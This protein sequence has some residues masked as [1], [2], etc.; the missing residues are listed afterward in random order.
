MK[1]FL[2][3]ILIAATLLCL[4][5]CGSG[6]KP[7]HNPERDEDGSYIFKDD[8]A[9]SIGTV[10]NPV[11]AQ[12]IYNSI[13]YIPEMFYGK[14]S[15]GDDETA[16]QSYRNDVGFMDVNEQTFKLPYDSLEKI[17]TIPYAIWAG[18]ENFSHV[19]NYI[20]NR[21]WANLYF[22]NE[23]GNLVSVY[24]A[25]EISDNQIIFTPLLNWKYDEENQK[26]SYQLS[27]VQFTYDF[28]FSGPHLTLSSGGKS[29]M[30]TA[31]R[32]TT[33]Q[34]FLMGEGY[35]KPG[36]EG[37]GDVSY[38][39]TYN[40][41]LSLSD[42][43]DDS[44]SA[45]IAKFSKDGLVTIT[46]SDELGNSYTRQMVYFLCSFDGYV[47]A[48]QQGVYC[49]TATWSEYRG[50]N[51]TGNI[52]FEEM[53]KLEN[54]PQDELTQIIEKKENL[55]TDLAAAYADSGLAV[56]INETTGEITLDS[57]V[58]FDVNAYEVSAEGKEFLKKFI[59]I[60]TSVVFAEKYDGFV[61]KII[62]EGH[63]D[64]NGDYDMNM[65]LSQ[66]RA[67]SVMNYCLSEECGIDADTLSA[68]QSTM[69]SVGYSFENPIYDENGD[70]DMAASRRVSFRFIVSLSN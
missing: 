28:S 8:D 20:T 40:G 15:L 66:N 55:L 13:D 21:S 7:I 34:Y 3:L 50:H 24:A 35:L 56:S 18:P 32:F 29:V 26:V 37:F 19:I 1:K 42:G 39:R 10:S 65:E 31:D 47:F 4:A 36:T 27:E 41:K 61:S 14:Y 70:V 43:N 57:S 49:Y 30:M 16:L 53:K 54:L 38:L 11:S 2:S 48:D 12:E 63:T 62:V 58:L 23:A 60:Y 44:L 69:I 59:G 6:S 52:S 25:Y 46:W 67:D 9:G 22:Q 45:E 64:T 68:L 5:A 51:L 17:T 33:D